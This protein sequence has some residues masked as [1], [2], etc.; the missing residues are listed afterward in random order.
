MCAGDEWVIDS[1]YGK[2]LEVERWFAGLPSRRAGG[3]L[4]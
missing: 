1:A 3:Q 2:W 4:R